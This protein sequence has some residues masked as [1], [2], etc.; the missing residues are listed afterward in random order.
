MDSRSPGELIE[1]VWQECRTRLCGV[2]TPATG[3]PGGGQSEAK[4]LREGLP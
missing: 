4:K 3:S 2:S 1:D